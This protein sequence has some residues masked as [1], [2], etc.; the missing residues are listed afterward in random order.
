MDKIYTLK[1]GEQ[2][3]LSS[4]SEAEI[5]KFAET[6]NDQI[7]WKKAVRTAELSTLQEALEANG[8]TLSE[9]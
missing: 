5:R 8:Y 4:V 3:I 9:D 6:I 2:V 1:K 7:A